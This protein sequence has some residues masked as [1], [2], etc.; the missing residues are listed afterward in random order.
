MRVLCHR[1]SMRTVKT[2]HLTTTWPWS[3]DMWPWWTS[4]QWQL[5]CRVA[6]CM[7]RWTFTFSAADTWRLI[8]LGINDRRHVVIQKAWACEAVS[9]WINDIT[10]ILFCQLHSWSCLWISCHFKLWYWKK[11][12]WGAATFKNSIKWLEK[13]FLILNSYVIKSVSCAEKLINASNHWGRRSNG[14][15]KRENSQEKSFHRKGR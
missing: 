7:N 5:S 2:C 9:R 3:Y 13:H 4:R 1:Q 8:T 11:K 10:E 15:V 14:H 6:A 12:R